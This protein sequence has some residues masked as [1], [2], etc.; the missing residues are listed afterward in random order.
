MNRNFHGLFIGVSVL[1]ALLVLPANALVLDLYGEETIEAGVYENAAHRY[2][3]VNPDADVTITGGAVFKNNNRMI[4]PIL[5]KYDGNGGAA[6]VEDETSTLNIFGTGKDKVVFDSNYSEWNA[7]AI[8]NHGQLY[9]A[10]AEFK[11]NY[12]TGNFDENGDPTYKFVVLDRYGNIVLDDKGETSYGDSTGGAIYNAANTNIQETSFSENK[13]ADGGAIYNSGTLSVAK[14]VFSSNYAKIGGGAILQPFDVANTINVNESKFV[15]NTAGYAG[16]I[17]GYNKLN[18]IKSEFTNNKAVDSDNNGGGAIMLGGHGKANIIE[19]VFTGNTANAGGAIATRPRGANAMGDIDEHKNANGEYVNK[20][21]HW[22]LIEKSSFVNNISGVDVDGNDISGTVV[23]YGRNSMISGD[24]G[25]IWN[26]FEG[27]TV[28]GTEHKNIISESTFTGNTAKRNGG[29]IYNEGIITISDTKFDKNI[30]SQNGGAIQNYNDGEITLAGINSFF[31]NKA[32]GV[33]NDINNLGLIT[34]ASGTTTINGGVSGNGT[35][36]VSDNA[37]L[38]IGTASVVQATIKLN[39]S[40]LATLRGG[41]TAQITANTFD[42]DGT[43][44]LTMKDAGTYK[45]F[46]NAKFANTVWNEKGLTADSP[47]YNLSWNGGDV[48]ATRKTISEIADTNTLSVETASAVSNMTDSSSTKLNNLSLKIQE[49]LAEKTSEAKA[50]VEQA[51]AAV[52]PEKESVVQ[53]VATSVQNTVTNLASAR[54]AS[55]TVGRNAGDVKLTSGGVWAQG[56]FNKSKQRDA[57]NGYTRGVAVGL[58]GTLNK[59]WTI[60][61][62]YSYAHSDVTGTARDTDIDSSTVF[63]YGQYKPNAWY[64]NTV[65]NYTMSDYSESGKALGIPVFADYDVDSF[66]LA[67]NTGYDFASGITPE[68]GLRYMHVNST[69]YVNSADV[70][71]G[72]QDNDFLTAVFGSKY[73]FSVV[74]DRYTTFVPQLN[75]GVKYDLLSD[76]NVANVTMPGINTYSLTGERLSRIGGEFGIGLGIKHRHVDISI[77][78]DIDV[79]KDYTSQTGMLKFRSNF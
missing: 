41:D 49:K 40:M 35:L 77:N 32:N 79:R 55:P 4:D 12:N 6:V 33:A 22:M 29:A 61:A 25:A 11:N 31:N 74:A 10:N 28:G 73:A 68:L 23:E 76:N 63:V 3:W 8:M 57:F 72:L 51:T 1:P 53:S 56:I 66:G 27:T 64:L 67:L 19:S 39:G 78:Y 70:K 65:A 34:V 75:A 43:L 24:G 2:F 60:G 47:L 62:G 50:A 36:V 38:N 14:G 18:V 37:T 46:G 15:G 45:V 9:I 59:K 13:S 44:T 20:D 69:N 21:G 58:D 7:G 42:G 16:A 71:T 54:M 48:T 5:G 52:H 17:G 26:G 30:A